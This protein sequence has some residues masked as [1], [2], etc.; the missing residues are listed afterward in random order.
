MQ[1]VV[2]NGVF[3]VGS[4]LI[5]VGIETLWSNV[6]QP[7]AQ[8]KTLNI[9]GHL[10]TVVTDGNIANQQAD[11]TLQE[12]NLKRLLATPLPNVE[13][14]CDSGAV[15]SEFLV[16]PGSTSGVRVVHG[17]DFPS[18]EGA[19]YATIRSFN[20]AVQAEY[21]LPNTGNFALEFSETLR[22][23]GGL[24]TYVVRLAVVGPLQRQLIYPRT[25]FCC[26]QHGRIVGYL[27][28]LSVPAPKFPQ[29]LKEAGPVTMTSPKRTRTTPFTYQGFEQTYSYSFE[30][31]A[32]LA[33]VPALYTG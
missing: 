8:V 19:E 26:E 3:A 24:P 5:N 22:F 10:L 2:G 14:F 6:G 21:P 17:P 7:Y 15:S 32:P 1:L 9:N 30:S 11:L 27:R 28:Y 18:G 16:N 31:I 23:W 12:N 33:G 29:A 4:V 13:F 20:F 25:P